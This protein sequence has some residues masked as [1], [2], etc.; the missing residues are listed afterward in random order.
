MVQQSSAYCECVSESVR[1]TVRYN[2]PWQVCDTVGAQP[3][4][5]ALRKIILRAA[6]PERGG[7]GSFGVVNL[8][9][10]C[11][12]VGNISILLILNQHLESASCSSFA[13][14]LTL[15]GNTRSDN[16][17]H[18]WNPYPFI[19]DCLKSNVPPRR[20]GLWMV[21]CHDGRTPDVS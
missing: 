5:N 4:D 9:C 18:H 6:G 12:P 2:I 7:W 19:W 11:Q 3:L 14:R 10:R 21:G 16:E 1:S 13:E 20:Q 17:S 15:I 8:S